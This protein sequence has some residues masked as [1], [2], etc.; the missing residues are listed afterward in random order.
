V[1]YLGIGSNLSSD[2][3]GPPVMNCRAAIKR[4]A[5]V[6]LAPDV[7]S[8]FYETAPLPASD[9]PWY[10]NCVVGLT[11]TTLIPREAL[12]AWLAVERGLGRVRTVPNAARI[13]D[14]DLIAWHDLVIDEP[15]DLIVPHPRMA[16]RAFVLR[17][18]ADIAPNWRHPRTGAAI[19]DLIARLP[20]DQP[21]R[22]LEAGP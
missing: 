14:I 2:A 4:L 3:F 17:P 1:I 20:K 15:P 7:L 16:E 13:A 22:L 18:L 6:G 12:A 11:E 21:I 8:P 9:Q 5:E 10:V 19:A